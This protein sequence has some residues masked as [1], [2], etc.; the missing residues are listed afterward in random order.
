MDKIT[1]YTAEEVQMRKKNLITVSDE[2]MKAF[3]DFLTQ[4]ETKAANLTKIIKEL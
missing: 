3:V 2:S 1:K 4:R